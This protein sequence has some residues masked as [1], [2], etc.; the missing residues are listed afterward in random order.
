MLICHD[1]T[2]MTDKHITKKAALRRLP[3]ESV[4]VYSHE[5]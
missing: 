3:S 5:R 2:D 4:C 1:R